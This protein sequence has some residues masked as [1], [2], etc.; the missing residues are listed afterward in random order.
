MLHIFYPKARFLKRTDY[1]QH[2]NVTDKDIPIPKSY[3]PYH[4]SFMT[5]QDAPSSGV[6]DANQAA[7]QIYL[8]A[9][10]KSDRLRHPAGPGTELLIGIRWSK[11]NT[12]HMA[13]M[14]NFIDQTNWRKLAQIDKK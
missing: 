11:P 1:F 5:V 8:A 4:A 10:D 12:A 9:C 7:E 13:E 14:C 6:A 2:F 3:Q